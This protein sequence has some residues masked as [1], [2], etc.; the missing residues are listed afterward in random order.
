MPEP[1]P[2]AGPGAAIM[3]NLPQAVV[4]GGPICSQDP[5]SVRTEP[6]PWSEGDRCAPRIQGPS[7]RRLCKIFPE[8]VLWEP[9]PDHFPAAGVWA[10]ESH[11]P[12][13]QSWCWSHF[14]S[15][16]HSCLSNNSR[17][18]ILTTLHSLEYSAREALKYAKD[19]EETESN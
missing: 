17:V 1:I 3:H 14:F 19:H 11:F 13:S 8:A 16:T 9:E 15:A 18:V 5:G 7:V 10:A 2:V 12:W 6:K 4:G